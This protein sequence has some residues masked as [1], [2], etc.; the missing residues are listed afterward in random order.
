MKLERRKDKDFD[1]GALRDD[2]IKVSKE[3]HCVA[4]RREEILLCNVIALKCTEKFIS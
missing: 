4:L 3:C 1:P 2:F